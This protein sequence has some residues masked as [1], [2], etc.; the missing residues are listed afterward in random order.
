L[1][2]LGWWPAALPALVGLV[3][4]QVGEPEEQGA[5]GGPDES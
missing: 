2:L 4:V 5:P 1:A 3:L